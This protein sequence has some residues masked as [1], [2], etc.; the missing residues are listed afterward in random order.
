LSGEAI[1][2]FTLVTQDIIT[3]I[4]GIW[5]L[6]RVIRKQGTEVSSSLSEMSVEMI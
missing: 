3:G 6:V 1:A 5:L 2:R 4:D